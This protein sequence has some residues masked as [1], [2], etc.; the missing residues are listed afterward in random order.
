MK[1]FDLFAKNW[2]EDKESS[3]N[4][5]DDEFVTVKVKKSELDSFNSVMGFID[6]ISDSPEREKARRELEEEER[7]NLANLEEQQLRRKEALNSLGVDVDCI[8]LDKCRSELFSIA[9]TLCDIDLPSLGPCE[10]ETVYW[11]ALT[12]TG[13]APKCVATYNTHWVFW[14]GGFRRG[15]VTCEVGYLS[16]GTPYTAWIN[17]LRGSGTFYKIKTVDGKL[18]L[19]AATPA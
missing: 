4:R 1:I 7:R 11:Q 10:R 6:A 15:S 9:K 16:D 13:K 5:G 14:E 18:E 17:D 8:T 2:K 3:V 12:R 19:I